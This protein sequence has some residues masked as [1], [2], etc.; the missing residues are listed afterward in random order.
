MS[1]SMSSSR[2]RASRVSAAN[3]RYLRRKCVKH[4]DSLRLL[5]LV[6]SSGQLSLY[7]NLTIPLYARSLVS[8]L[9]LCLR[10]TLQRIKYSSTDVKNRVG[11]RELLM[12]PV[13]RIPRYTL[14]F[15]T[16]VKHMAPYDPQRAKLTEA[17]EIASKIALAET[18]DKTKQATIMYC[19]SATI[20]EFPAWLM[21]HSRRK[22]VD[23]IDAEDVPTESISNTSYNYYSHSRHASNASGGGAD[24]SGG[25]G[26]GELTF[27]RSATS[28][29]IPVHT[30]LLLVRTAGARRSGGVAGAQP[31]RGERVPRVP[32]GR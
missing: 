3:S 31:R 5:M 25:A 32:A 24:G 30:P 22:F 17:D 23:C 2:S 10:T 20:D 6:V 21:S 9:L 15:R 4:Q 18:D 12:D 8:T 29:P 14:M 27:T 13:Q 19:L 16:M 7:P 28:V 1:S 11:L 26:M